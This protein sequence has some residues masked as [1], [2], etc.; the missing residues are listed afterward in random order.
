MGGQDNFVGI[1]R[2]GKVGI[3]FPS[4]IRPLWGECLGLRVH[5]QPIV[6]C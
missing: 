5:A 6:H 3:N 1:G 2:K 4:T